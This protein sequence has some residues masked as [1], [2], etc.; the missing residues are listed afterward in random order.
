MNRS[1]LKILVKKMK[2]C[3]H[4]WVTSEIV[5]DFDGHR[6][7]KIPFYT[8]IKCGLDTHSKERVDLNIADDMN[9]EMASIIDKN[10]LS[11]TKTDIICSGYLARGIYNGLIK[12][13]PDISDE[14]A[15]KYLNCALSNI[16][17][18]K[19]TDNVKK[20]RIKRLGLYPDFEKWNKEDIIRRYY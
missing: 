2:E 6:I 10:G 7:C 5:K 8:C 11:G 14:D 12:V 16:R 4:I 18:N 3:N 17:N 15:V 9:L 19:V 13:H 1:N 20:K